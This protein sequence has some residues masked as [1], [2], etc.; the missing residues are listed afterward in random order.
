MKRMLVLLI[1]LVLALQFC[2]EADAAVKPSE[3]K[4]VS[5][6]NQVRSGQNLKLSAGLTRL[7][8][9]HSRAMRR[10]DTLYHTNNLGSKV[11]NWTSLGENVGVGGG[12]ASLHRAFM[13][14]P[15]HRANILDGRFS[16]VGVGVVK[17]GARIWVTII[18][19][20]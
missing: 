8:R 12:V 6:M 4:F 15:G 20:A 1:G 3:R 19:K 13:Q 11:Q 9:R 14:S 16:K 5:K 7:A 10:A 18:F 17:D 2:T